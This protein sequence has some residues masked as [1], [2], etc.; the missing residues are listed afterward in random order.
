MKKWIAIAVL[1]TAV[2]QAGT[3]D[4]TE[5]IGMCLTYDFM[6]GVDLGKVAEKADSVEAQTDQYVLGSLTYDSA[7][8]VNFYIEKQGRTIVFLPKDANPALVFYDYRTKGGFPE[9]NNLFSTLTKLSKMVEVAIDTPPDYSYVPL[10]DCEHMFLRSDHIT[11]R[12]LGDLEIKKAFVY[13]TTPT[14]Q[15]NGT[16]VELKRFGNRG[17]LFYV[18]NDKRYPE[19]SIKDITSYLLKSIKLGTDLD[20]SSR[21]EFPFH[22]MIFYRETP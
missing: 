4:L 15:I 8:K 11:L 21:R 18:G 19:P 22:V 17:G 3:V 6:Q 9:N 1:M 12:S 13:C 5:Q 10:Q 2:C 7:L 16:P 20:I 14:I